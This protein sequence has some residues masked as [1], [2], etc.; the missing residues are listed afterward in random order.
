MAP[1]LGPKKTDGEAEAAAKS[2]G[3]PMD[4]EEEEAAPA[5]EGAASDAAA[6]KDGEDSGDGGGKVDGEE[7]GK[8]AEANGVEGGPAALEKKAG[9]AAEKEG[10]AATESGGGKGEQEGLGI[11]NGDGKGGQGSPEAK[12]RFH[13]TFLSRAVCGVYASCCGCSQ[14]DV[15]GLF[16]RRG[17]YGPPNILDIRI[18]ARAF[19]VPMLTSMNMAPVM[20]SQ[21]VPALVQSLPLFVRWTYP[22]DHTVRPHSAL[23]GLVDKS[24]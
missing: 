6:E 8:E 13:P 18:R 7:A 20:G 5:D 14:I 15:C 23:C 2:G 10:A 12:R 9:T 21:F 4:D 19:A 3:D 1:P 22:L 17:T 24:I 16:C 11:D